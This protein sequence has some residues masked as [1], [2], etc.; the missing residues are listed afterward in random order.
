MDGKQTLTTHTDYVNKFPSILQTTCYN[1]TGTHTTGEMCAVIVKPA[2]IFPKNPA[3]HYSDLK[4]LSSLP[5]FQPVFTNSV[6]QSSKPI[7]CVRV[8]GAG[9]ERPS[10]LEVQFW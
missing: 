4:V 7:E 9:D 2:K 8:D 3:Q 5:E 1:F 6:S 10:H